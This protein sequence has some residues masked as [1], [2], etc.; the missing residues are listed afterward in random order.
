MDSKDILII[1]QVF[2]PDPASVGQHLFDVAIEMSNRGYRIGVLTA[3]EGYDNP[4]NKY[5]EFEKFENID[6]FRI[7]NTS[8]GKKTFLLRIMGNM[9]F[10]LKTL[11]LITFRFKAKSILITTVPPI[12]TLI[13]S[14]AVIFL[15]KPLFYWV[16]DINPDQ[17][18]ALGVVKAKSLGVR[19]LD[20]FNRI[21]LK[22]AQL[23]VTLDQYMLRTLKQKTTVDFEIKVIP[24]WPHIETTK[25]ICKENNPFVN[26]Y[27]LINKFVVMYSGNHSPSN[28]LD[29]L[30]KIAE[31]LEEDN[32]VIFVFVGGGTEKRKV[33]D[34][35]KKGSSKYS[36]F[37][38]SAFLKVW[39]NF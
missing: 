16:M 11:F 24:P 1:S 39:T 20:F 25:I 13:G 17:A 21:V 8:F 23:I 5:P 3:Q 15:R 29:T 18:V 27:N 9:F 26:K 35:L 2:P 12:S 22:R 19:F 6:I 7:K 38:L 31:K 30:L 10:C 14:Y 33:E 32:R 34:L 28:P 36:F 4:T 37:T